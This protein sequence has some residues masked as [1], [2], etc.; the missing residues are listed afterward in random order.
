L[1]RSLRWLSLLVRN[2][3]ATAPTIGCP[4]YESHDS[5]SPPIATPGTTT[6][7]ATRAKDVLRRAA[8]QLRREVKAR[9][10]GRWP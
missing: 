6:R 3:C 2:D 7:P 4:L 8:A 1:D 5:A 10:Q 9:V